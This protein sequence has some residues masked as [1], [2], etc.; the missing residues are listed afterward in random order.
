M[1]QQGTFLPALQPLSGRCGTA[2]GGANNV[3]LKRGRY[4][5]DISTL[6]E[7]LMPCFAPAEEFCTRF[8]RQGRAQCTLS[9][10]PQLPKPT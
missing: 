8:I 1:A 10:Q 3:L 6:G 4:L 7:R 2:T 9:W 5:P